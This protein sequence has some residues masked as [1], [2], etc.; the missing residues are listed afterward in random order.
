MTC[1]KASML[2][3]LL[4]LLVSFSWIIPAHPREDFL[5]CLSLHFED[6]AAMSN[7]VH[8]PYNSSYSSILQFSIRNLRFNSSELKPLVI[9]TPTNASHIQAAILCSQRHNLQIRIR[10]GGH[11]FEGLSYMAAVPFV[12]I[13]LISL[14]AVN[15]DATNRTAWVQAGATLGELYYSISEKSRTLA[16]PAGSCPTIG[17]G[18]HFSGGGHGTMVRKFGLASDNVIDAHLIDSK[19][20]ILDRASMGEDLF[21]AIRGGGGQSFGV[22]VAW[23]ISLVEVPSTVTMF[24]VSRTLEQNA[25][26]LLHRWQYV[27]NTLPED[28][29]IDVLV[30]RVNSSQE[31]NTTIQATFFSLFLGE[32]DQ[33][34]PVMQGSFPELGLVKDDC[35][36][37]SW[38][39][40]VFYT[41]GFTSNASLDVLL[42][43]TP[44]SIPRFKAKSDYVKEP[45]PEIAFEGIWERFFEEDIEV[46]ALILIPYG[47]KMDEISESSTPFPH[48]A[49][50][51]YV[52]VSSVSWSEESKEASR[53][54]VA[55]IRRLYSYLTTYVSNNPREAYV[56]YRDLDLG[57]NNL[58]GTT[59]Y[60]QASIW[61]R[62]YFKNN[63]ERLVR[64]K[65]EV[66][67]TNFFRNE[68]S[69]P[70][71]SSW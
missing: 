51:L 26:K 15:V 23:K 47:G 13:D 28:I 18:G 9:V 61:G 40:S 30:T 32:V 20:R 68:Q 22:V 66:D 35:F 69:I 59:S 43:R 53:R 48:R 50:N 39:E 54:H 1:L 71:L 2:P 55:W 33:L 41:G 57:I 16:F 49:G 36:E 65:T 64:V 29:V 14:R 31:G 4:C 10:S 67:P 8:T 12:I 45:L 70:S 60:K 34:L 62:K 11:D 5:K 19:G 46:P 38:I 25:T 56:N 58:T 7:V 44:R 21:W 42:N 63:F 6:S 3:F 52:L 37:M 24:S 27:A 17:V